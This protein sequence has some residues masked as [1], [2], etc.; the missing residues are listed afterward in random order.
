[1]AK[2]RTKKTSGEAAIQAPPSMPERKSVE[3]EEAENGYIV[4]V[5]H[6][7]KGGY[8]SKRYVA[9][10]HPEALRIAAQGMHSMSGKKVSKKKA[11]RGKKFALKKS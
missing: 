6:E 1:M 5:S 4:R 3:T 11:G 2:R 8:K 9:F 7:G 10:S